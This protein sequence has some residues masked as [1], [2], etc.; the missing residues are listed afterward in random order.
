MGILRT[1]YENYRGRLLGFVS[2]AS[3]KENRYKVPYYPPFS[4]PLSI[5]SANFHITPK[6]SISST[7]EPWPPTIAYPTVVHTITTAGARRTGACYSRKVKLQEILIRYS[8]L[9]HPGRL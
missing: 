2:F 5:K 9:R 8:L 1:Y 7:L 6:Y 3:A 4:A